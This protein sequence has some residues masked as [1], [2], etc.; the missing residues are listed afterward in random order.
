MTV[1]K[2]GQAAGSTHLGLELLGAPLQALALC[3]ASLQ[4]RRQL[5]S[6]QQGKG[7]QATS[8][9]QAADLRPPTEQLEANTQRPNKAQQPHLLLCGVQL[10]LRMRALHASPVGLRLQRLPR[11][12]LRLQRRLGVALLPLHLLGQAASNICGLLS[13]DDLQAA[14]A[15]GGRGRRGQQ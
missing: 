2:V 8:Q 7:S 6:L 13:L 12:L 3:L 5:S 1:C 10:V 4:L 15:A 11:L 9:R 14:A